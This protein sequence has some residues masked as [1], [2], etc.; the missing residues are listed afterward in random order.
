MRT[1]IVSLL[2]GVTLGIVCLGCAKTIPD[3]AM[4]SWEQVNRF[5]NGMC[6][7]AATFGFEAAYAGFSEDQMHKEL[8]ICLEED[9]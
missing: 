2:V 9:E 1:K 5:Y 6:H 8:R 7:A 3:Q 4:V